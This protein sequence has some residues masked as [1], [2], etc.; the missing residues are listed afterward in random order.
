MPSGRF[1]LD[2]NG[3]VMPIATIWFISPDHRYA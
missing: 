2:F 1:I 3:S